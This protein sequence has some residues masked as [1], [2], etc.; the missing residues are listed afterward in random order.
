MDVILA[1]FPGEHAAAV[2]ALQE[3]LLD[4]VGE[5]DD[6]DDEGEVGLYKLRIQLN[7]SLK[8]PGFNLSL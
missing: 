3:A 8:A 1:D 5:G 2:R 4:M 7:H 6:E